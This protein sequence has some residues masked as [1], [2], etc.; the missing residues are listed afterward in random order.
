MTTTLKSKISCYADDRIFYLYNFCDIF[1][2]PSGV[3]MDRKGE[4][5]QWD[6]GGRNRRKQ[7]RSSRG[8]R[9][10]SEQQCPGT[11]YTATSPSAGSSKDTNT[12]GRSRESS[13]S[14]GNNLTTQTAAQSESDHS[15]FVRDASAGRAGK[16]LK[17]SSLNDCGNAFSGTSGFCDSEIEGPAHSIA[18]RGG[19]RTQSRPF[20]PPRNQ[21]YLQQTRKS[22]HC[23]DGMDSG[24]GGRYNR[25]GYRN[26]RGRGASQ[27]HTSDRGDNSGGNFVHVNQQSKSRNDEQNDRAEGGSRGKGKRKKRNK[28]TKQQ[29]DNSTPSTSRECSQPSSSS[30]QGKPNNGGAKLGIL[31]KWFSLIEFVLF[32]KLDVPNIYCLLCM[33]GVLL[34]CYP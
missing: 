26:F 22:A 31:W 6:R 5:S 24:S 25:G 8:S 9:G 10:G 11:S 13:T 16:K 28:G 32:S 17:Q 3:T 34:C 30:T 33:N 19:L 1:S 20:N 21:D 29:S 12:W 18:G 27:S 15:P 14:S 23:K 7:S 4:K 2:G